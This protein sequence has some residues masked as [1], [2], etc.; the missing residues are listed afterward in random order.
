MHLPASPPRLLALCR[1][2][3]HDRRLSEVRAS[4]RNALRKGKIRRL[5]CR[6]EDEEPVV[7]AA[8][9]AQAAAAD[10]DVSGRFGSPCMVVSVVARQPCFSWAVVKQRQLD[11]KMKG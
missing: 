7:R 10:D 9:E 8:V 6:L 3:G 4:L 5:L 1:R 2:S 11:G